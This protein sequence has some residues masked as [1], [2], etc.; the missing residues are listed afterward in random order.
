M[1]GNGEAMSF[2]AIYAIE[3]RDATGYADYRAAMLPILANYG[4]AFRFDFEVARTLKAPGSKAL[5]RV[6]VIRFPDASAKEAFFA[7]PE[8]LR[9]RE[10]Y[11]TASV[12]EVAVIA[13]CEAA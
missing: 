4:G 11:F 2:D 9:V 12:G 1:Q 5:N 8:Y 3:V 13:E 6:F 10:R 7:D